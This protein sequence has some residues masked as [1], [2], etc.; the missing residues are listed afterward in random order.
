MMSPEETARLVEAYRDGTLGAE[1][2]RR[3]AEAIRGGGEAS[4]EVRRHL[5]FAGLLGQALD[6]ADDGAF[7]RGL[8]ARLQAERSESEFVR[9]LDRRI[10]SRHLR[11]R[12]SR[13]RTW[14]VPLAAAAAAVLALAAVLSRPPRPLKPREEAPVEARAEEPAERTSERREP[15]PEPP[16]PEPLP[17]PVIRPEPPPSAPLPAPPPPVRDPAPPAPREEPRPAPAV[18]PT[19]VERRAVATVERVEGDVAVLSGGGQ[20]RKG[21]GLAPGQGLQTGPRSQAA[22]VF[23]DG[24]RLVLGADTL[25]REIPEAAK[26]RGRRI[27]LGTGTVSAEV[28]K[29]PADQPLVF[30]TPHA[31]ARVLG[32]SF[33]LVIDAAATRLEVRE[34]RVR[35][36]REKSGLDVSGG[37]YAVAGGSAPPAARSLHPDEIVLWARDAKVAGTE[38]ALVRDARAA[39]GFALD[40]AQYPFKVV[41]H[42]DRRPAHATWTFFASADREY[43]LWLRAASQATGDPWLREMVVLEPQNAELSHKSPFFGTAPT[44]AFVF[45]GIASYA[46]YGYATPLLEGGREAV[47]TVRF[48][49]T[50]WQTLRAFTGHPSIRIDAVW[51]SAGQVSKPPHRQP[52][53]VEGK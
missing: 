14:A 24:T 19:E 27:A 51:L 34:G 48:R 46:G 20:A 10:S 17:P 16:R 21:Q 45:G 13:A 26:V 31:E 42:V 49:E 41:D 2:A 52:P 29:Q 25:I 36:T 43:R 33:R 39:G 4:A 11:L 18:V 6:P 23:S 38:W 37:Q 7:V 8:E 35:L 28:V 44:T 40:T 1:D 15:E 32:T 47:L 22:V 12:P 53:P 5:E 30:V 50:G 9:A 3:L